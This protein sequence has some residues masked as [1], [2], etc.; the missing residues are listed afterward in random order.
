MHAKVLYRFRGCRDGERNVRTFNPG[1]TIT[2]DLARGMVN[3]GFAKRDLGDAP[4]NK[5]MDTPSSNKR[6]TKTKD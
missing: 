2:G 6:R 4:R 3:A 5:A 1:D